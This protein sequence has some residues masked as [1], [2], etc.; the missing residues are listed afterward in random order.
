MD[1]QLSATSKGIINLAS[2]VTVRT[3]SIDREF[4][5]TFRYNDEHK[6]IHL[7][8]MAAKVGEHGEA[9]LSRWLVV[10]FYPL[11]WSLG[12]EFAAN[13]RLT[14]SECDEIKKN[15]EEALLISRDAP[16]QRG[17]PASRVAFDPDIFARILAG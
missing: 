6:N 3:V 11:D 17:Q 1:P 12:K 8:F 10:F 9:D 5:V 7:H 16:Y 2:G 13:R 15:I 14:R 4:S